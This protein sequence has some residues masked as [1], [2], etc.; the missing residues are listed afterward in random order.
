MLS[1]KTFFFVFAVLLVLGTLLYA[2]TPNDFKIDLSRNADAITI[3]GY[4]GNTTKVVIPT[5]IEGIPVRTI[6]ETAFLGNKNITEIVIPESV[7][8]IYGTMAGYGRGAFRDCIKLTSVTIPNSVMVIGDGAFAGCTSLVSILI[9]DS[10]TKIG[11]SAFNGCTNL[12]SIVI[13]NSVTT[14]GSWAFFGCINLTAINIPN[15]VTTIGT[16][17]FAG[18]NKLTSLIIPEG[19]RAIGTGA[20]ADCRSLVLIS[21]PKSITVIGFQAFANCSNLTTITLEDEAKIRFEIDINNNRYTQ[22]SGCGKLDVRSQIALKRAG[23]PGEF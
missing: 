5:E 3:T 4:T 14:I 15:R 1:K 9:P 10:V 12:A 13:P 23:F 7:N 20:F 2:Q 18:C 8:T 6:G 16:R 17:T 22:F 19:V 11:E 21:I